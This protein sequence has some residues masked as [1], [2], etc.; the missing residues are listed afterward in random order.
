MEKTVDRRVR[1]TKNQL[2]QG[3]ARLMLEKSLKEIT[4]K[5]LTDLVDMNRGTFYLHYRDI[6]DMVEK[7]EDTIMTEFQ[8]ILDSVSDEELSRSLLPLF[9]RIYAYLAENA[10]LCAAFLGE[11]GD[12]TFLERLKGLVHDKCFQTW[13]KKYEHIDARQFEY[14]YAFIISGH[15]GLIQTWLDTGMK[16]SPEEIA[17]LAAELSLH[18]G[19]FLE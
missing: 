11:K 3:L 15:I 4:V 10:D 6:Y 16:E 9:S 18:G 19:Q 8:R 7:I 2:R 13:E 14:F 1:K 5:E 17:A 12:I